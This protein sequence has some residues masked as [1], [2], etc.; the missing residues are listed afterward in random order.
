MKY[1]E[2][3]VC[4]FEPLSYK[5]GPLEVK[6]TALAVY[7]KLTDRFV[8][9]NGQYKGL[10]NKDFNIVRGHI[11]F[12]NGRGGKLSYNIIKDK[13]L[14]IY[15]FENRDINNIKETL[16]LSLLDTYIYVSKSVYKLILMPYDKKILTYIYRAN[17]LPF[18]MNAASIITH[19]TEKIY[20]DL[21]GMPMPKEEIKD[22]NKEPNEIK[23]ENNTSNV[24]IYTTDSETGQLREV[25]KQDLFNALPA[26]LKDNNQESEKLNKDNIDIIS[27][28]DEVS[29]KIVG[30]DEAIKSLVTNIY[31]NQVLI[32]ELSKSVNIDEA[33]LDSRKVNILIDGSTGTGKTAIAKAVAAK[34]DL[35]IVITNANSFSE[36]GYV[37]PTITDMLKKLINR[38]DGDVKK[39][40]RGIIVLDEI[41]KIAVDKEFGHSMKKGVQEE[42]L[43]FIGGGKY[44]VKMHS[45]FGHAITFDTSK[46]TFILMG[47]FTDI[48]EAKIKENNSNK[49]G[50]GDSDDKDKSYTITP[51]DY[52]DYGLMREFFGRIKVLV[53][54]KTYSKEALMNIL[55]NSNVSPLKNLEKNAKMFG[56]GGIDYNQE[57]INRIVDEAYEM[58]TGARG[59]QT[60]ISG[61]QN[62]LLMEM[63][64][65]NVNDE[66][67]K[68][69]LTEETLDEYKK[70]KVIKY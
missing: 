32:D 47:A 40:E 43:T 8:I 21:Y 15:I 18:E 10:S 27:I 42:L 34:F 66:N 28:I 26:K 5:S 23:K 65:N 9:K 64:T 4:I 46:I 54:T 61:I 52:I 70:T 39:A 55:L 58:N 2:R 67:K 29:S 11:N 36:T 13:D 51:Q 37:G 33:E 7:N 25:S 60:V 6:A 38:A 57:F 35:P 62:K 63:I 59:L 24:L 14:F 12:I 44:D 17:I 16:G 50:F 31:Y 1:Q 20:E 30:Q 22:D 56:Y 3:L 53:S 19:T 41:D 69:E 48:R 68:M 49:I 45:Q